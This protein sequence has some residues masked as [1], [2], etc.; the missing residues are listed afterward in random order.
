MG[1]RRTGADR[2]SLAALL[3]V[4]LDELLGVLLQDLI[5][6][7]EDVVHLL[8]Q[9]LALGGRGGLPGLFP[10]VGLPLDLLLL[11]FPQCLRPPLR[12]TRSILGPESDPVRPSGVAGQA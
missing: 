6:L 11:L 2:R 3:D 1:P 5:D 10:T 9:L 12:G 4:G 7:I 8:L